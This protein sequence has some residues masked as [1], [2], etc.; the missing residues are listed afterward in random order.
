LGDGLYSIGWF[1][2]DY[3][4]IMKLDLEETVFWQS[5]SYCGEIE[6][7]AVPPVVLVFSVDQKCGFVGIMFC[8]WRIFRD[9]RYPEVICLVVKIHF[10]VHPFLFRW[11]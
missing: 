6:A 9:L 7:M 3:Q 10:T 2:R 4:K 5:F 8:S 11:H 1:M